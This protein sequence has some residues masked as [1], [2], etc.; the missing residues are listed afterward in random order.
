MADSTD[1]L[2]AMR[3][4]MAHIMAAAI[5]RLWPEVKLGVGPVVEHGFYYDVDIPNHK[6]TEADLEKIEAEMIK[7][8]E[9]DQNFEQS[10]KSI[11]DALKWSKESGQPYKEELLNDLN[12]AGTTVVR[13]LDP[14][15]LG[16]SGDGSEVSEV[17][18]YTNRDF[19][20]L[21][22]GPHVAN[23]SEVG[24]FKLMRVAGA[25]WRGDETKP[26]M[27]RIYGV[28]F[29]SQEKLD[30]YLKMLKEAKKRDH[31][32]IGRELDLFTFSDMVGS[33]LP[34]FT[35]R[36][37]WLR[38]L[39]GRYS[40]DL[41]EKRGFERVWTPHI[42]KPDLYK[43]SG[44]WDKF[45]DE[46]FKVESQESSDSFAMK[47]MN[48]PHHTRVYDSKP[49][50]YKDL[51]VRYMENTTD[52]RDEKTGE[53]HGLSRVRSLT[54]DDSHVFCTE[55][56]IEKEA[57]QLVQAAQEMYRM[58]DMELKFV[59]SFRD[60]GDGYLG[61]QKLWDSAQ[62]KLEEL[63]K[64]NNLDYRID[65]GEAAF[66]GPKID[67]I[68]TDAIGREWQVA[69]V[70][71]DFVQP[72]RFELEYTA[73]DG[74]RKTPVMIHCALLGTIERFMSVYIEHTNGHFPIWLAPEQ[75]RILAINDSVKDYVNS[76]TDKLDELVLD[77]PLKFNPVRYSLDDRNVSLGKKIKEAQNLKIPLIL[78][79][80]PRDQEANTI[81]VRTQEGE[82]SVALDELVDWIHEQNRRSLQR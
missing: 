36:G 20:D 64:N 11:K 73:S 32:K 22:R 18:F 19:T 27:Q 8:V 81:S 62:H 12:R 65:Q 80:G 67:F 71:L 78:I 39:L 35:P 58:L 55:Q 59:L 69:T 56:Q 26:Q 25:Y 75:V 50:S 13:D 44:H 3:H 53:L 24:P 68:A 66:Y 1:E 28:G 54:Q 29:A 70:Q 9:E 7:I 57:S 30:E 60:D 49:R 42:T 16:V 48:C 33:G 5:K 34:M 63:A 14:S 40:Q 41:R 31:R 79:V 10:T 43:K 76:I 52:Y 37:T 4:S 72:A 2:Y 82:D 45:G 15:Q 6:I 46:L 47:P 23:T 77:Q 51:P 17:S 61:D 74:S 21:C 38:E